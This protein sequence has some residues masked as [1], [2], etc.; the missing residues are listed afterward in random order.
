MRVMGAVA[1]VLGLGEVDT[2][3]EGQG[4]LDSVGKAGEGEGVGVPLPLPPPPL[5]PVGGITV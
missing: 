4:E 2:L 5:E 3:G 1:E